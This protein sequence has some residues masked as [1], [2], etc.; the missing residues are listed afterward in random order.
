MIAPT[1]PYV[2]WGVSFVDLDLDGWP[3]LPIANGHL[4][5]QLDQVAPQRSQ[6]FSNGSDSFQASPAANGRGYR[7]RNL[8]FRNLGNRRFVESGERA[9][10]GF[11]LREALSS[12][13][14]AAG[15]INNDG[16]MDLVV[17]SLD[18]PPSLLLNR[19]PAG[20]WLLVKLK[21]RTS[22]RSAVG[23]T[24]TVRTGAL[25]QRRDVKSGGSYQ[26][27]SDLRLHFG[28]A[29][30]STIDELTIRWPGGRVVT[31][32]NVSANRVLVVEEQ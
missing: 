5:P 4:Y 9:G 23:A 14:L 13:G 16:L 29:G 18:E 28:L 7:Q 26:S 8:L 20:N 17:T 3:D 31:Q 2:G 6:L 32:R 27:Q 22:N 12:R 25:V 10:S 30:S 11:R 21:G 19:S 1:I 15:D 24:V